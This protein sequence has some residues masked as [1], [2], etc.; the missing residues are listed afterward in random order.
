MRA[1]ADALGVELTVARVHD[2]AAIEQAVGSI[3]QAGDGG[4]VFPPDSYSILTN[5]RIIQIAA[6][7]RVPAV[8]GFG[9]FVQ[10]GGLISYGVNLS[11]Q[12]S[13]AATYIDRILKGTPPADLPVQ[14]PTKY[15]L[16]INLKIAKALGIVIPPSLLAQADE[17][18]E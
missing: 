1:S 6:E 3:A 10:R 7:Y 15:E 2:G 8:Y 17:V 12:Y 11:A 4:L 16:V 9:E 18:I 14:M 13:E 5:G